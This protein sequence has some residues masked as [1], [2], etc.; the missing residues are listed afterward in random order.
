MEENSS[1]LML[2]GKTTNQPL[3]ARREERDILHGHYM[4]LSTGFNYLHEKIEEN[5][6]CSSE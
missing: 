6:S 2:R 4:H 1:Y 5:R 3:L